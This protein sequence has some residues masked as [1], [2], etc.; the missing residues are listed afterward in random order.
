MY[1]ELVSATPDDVRTRVR[2]S[3]DIADKLAAILKEKGMTRRDLARR[4]GKKEAEVSRWLGGGHN[5][6]IGT[7]AKISAAL[8]CD[9]V[10]AK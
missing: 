3:F 8:G 10:S 1:R 2:L 5:F 4:M 6:T 7:L 9:I